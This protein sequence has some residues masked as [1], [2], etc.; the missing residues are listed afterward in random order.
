ME[1]DRQA[2]ADIITWDVANWSR[3]L[4]CWNRAR[5][6]PKPQAK[7]LELGGRNGGL[8]LYLALKGYQVVCSDY[9]PPPPTSLGMMS[10]Y[11]V[12]HRVTYARVNATQIAFRENSFDVVALKSVLGSIGIHG[13]FAAQQKTADEIHRVLRPGGFWLFAENLKGAAIHTFF[14]QR[15]VKWGSAYYYLTIGELQ[16]LTSQF[17][18]CH[19]ETY[20]YF[21][22]LGRREWQRRALS[23]LDRGLHPIFPEKSR[24]LIYGYARK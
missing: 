9:W 15:F 19:Y 14:R 21:G 17:S 20:G 8:S 1:L 6:E 5:I 3:A 11:E 22:C 24:Y 12:Q 2:Y 4:D 23:V 13:G 18:D 16:R 7:A 10:R